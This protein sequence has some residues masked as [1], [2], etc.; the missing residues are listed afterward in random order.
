[1]I[2]FIKDSLQ[3]LGLLVVWLVVGIY[4]GPIAYAFIPATAYLLIQK[5][6][7]TDLFLGFFFILILSDSRNY[8]LLFAVQTKY[9]FVVLL[10][11]FAILRTQR[12]YP[13]NQL[14]K[15]FIPF[16]VVAIIC[17]LFSDTIITS[18][19]KTLSYLLVYFIVPN[20]FLLM[21]KH[22]EVHAL[23]GWIFFGTLLLALGILLKYITP[24]LVTLEGRFSGVLGNPNGLGIF[25]LLFFLTTY[26][27]NSLLPDIFTKQEKTIT[28]TIIIT[29][30]LLCGS[31]GALVAV[32]LFFI[33]KYLY[34]K[35]I[36]L[37]I[38]VFILISISY[39]YINLNIPNII[40]TLGLE[41]YFRLDTLEDGSGRIIA[42]NFAWENIQENFFLGKGISYTELLF[43]RNYSALSILGHQGN[44]HN[45]YLTFWL[46]TGLIGLITYLGGFFLSFYRGSKNSNLSIAIMFAVMFSINIESWLTASLNPFTIQ[47][48]IILTLLTSP[49]IHAKKEA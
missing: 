42:W 33:I 28:Y 30:M 21:L 23:R 12:F 36:I 45:S 47:L 4:G 20:F 10:G 14:Y 39:E 22:E 24:E 9:V 46:D 1:M 15:N 5:E 40:M 38:I 29:S 26:L 2:T 3:F 31:R 43:K 7:F 6:R 41:E 18:S 37:V 8:S 44:A 17:L 27:I 34:N 32:F 48:L 19:Q 11:V 35:S 49:Q 13:L 16:F 25:T